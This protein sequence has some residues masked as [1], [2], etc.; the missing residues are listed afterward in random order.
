MRHKMNL[1]LR[2][3]RL[4]QVALN[5]LPFACS[6][7]L[8]C[9]CASADETFLVTLPPLEDPHLNIVQ[10]KA[11]EAAR[12]AKVTTPTLDFTQAQRFEERPAGAA[13][14]RV[15]RNANA[16]SLPSGNISFEDELNFKLGN[17]LFRKLWVSSP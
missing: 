8:V 10:R 7:A 6:L 17:G 16:F 4:H 2:Q 15:L 13:T 3:K 14:V 11:D 1:T 12:I 5:A 9:T